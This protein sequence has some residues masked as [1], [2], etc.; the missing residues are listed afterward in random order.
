[1]AAPLSFLGI[2]RE[3]TFSP[4]KVR[5]DAR[6]LEEVAVH[7]ASRDCSV[8]VVDVVEAV[9]R[10][11]SP[12]TVVFA[13]CQ[14]EEALAL[15]ERWQR[16]GVRVINAPAAIRG[17][18]RTVMV[19]RLQAA[20]V[21]MPPTL[22]VDTAA[23]VSARDLEVVAGGALWVK[24]GDVHATTADDVVRIDDPRLVSGVL[25]RF[26][27]RGIAHAALQRHVEGVVVKFYATTSGFFRAITPSVPLSLD[28]SNAI[29]ALGRAAA[30]ALDLEVYGGDCVVGGDGDFSLI[31][32][33]D[34]PSYAPC[35][36]QAAIAIADHI[37][38]QKVNLC[39]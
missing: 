5:A 22:I 37:L 12:A 25:Q 3:A 31:D 10:E 20:G 9:R 38:A 17:C 13:M 2:R 1:M 30:V 27:A 14:G 8:E 34:W 35:R 19:P 23:P 15:L 36:A 11:P 6:I 29:A 18:H 28:A 21:S 7:L 33:N 39:V 16:G 32:M 4:G 26:V 24:R